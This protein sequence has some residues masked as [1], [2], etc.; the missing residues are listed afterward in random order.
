[1]INGKR[2]ED[3]EA[4]GFTSVLAELPLGATEI[5]EMRNDSGGWHHP[6][7]IH[8]VDMKIL[9][10]QRQARRAG[11][12]R[13]QHEL[14][15]K[16]VFYLGENERVRVIANFGPQSGRYMMHCHNLVHEDHSMMGQFRVV[17]PTDPHPVTTARPRNLPAPPL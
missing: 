14:G 8:L 5:W 16:D 6:L 11:G 3:V 12:S 9:D 7:H 1:M 13:C 10:R 17:G 15:P 2:W 4:S